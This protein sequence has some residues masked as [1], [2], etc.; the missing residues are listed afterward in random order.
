MNALLIMA[1]KY[2]LAVAS[3]LIVGIGVLALVSIIADAVRRGDDQ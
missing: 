3:L 2:F 1:G